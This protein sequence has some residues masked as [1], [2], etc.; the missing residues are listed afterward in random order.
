MDDISGFGEHLAN[1]VLTILGRARV[2]STADLSI[3]GGKGFPTTPLE[4]EA[5][6]E[7][8]SA[9]LSAERLEQLL[10]RYGT[11][12]AHVISHL[13]GEGDEFLVHHQGYSKG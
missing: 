1:E 12:A 9:V 2:V 6:V 10:H 3:G 4:R 7:N 8:H 13:E 11:Y 5:W